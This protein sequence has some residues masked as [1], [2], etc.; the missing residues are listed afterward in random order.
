MKQ[1]KLFSILMMLVLCCGTVFAQGITITG[2]ITDAKTSES[3]PGASGVLK[4]TTQGTI[5]DMDGKYSISATPGA[6]LVI[7][8]IGY[9]TKEVKVGNQ[10]VI[11]VTLSEDSQS[12]DEVVIVGAS[13]KKSDLTGAISH[14]DAKVLEER[15]VTTVNE[16]LQGRVA[17]VLITK[18]TRPGDDSSI[19][20]RGVNTINSGSDPI[21]VVDGLV[22][23]N[24][25]GGFNAINVNDVASVQVLKD[26]SATAL[27]GSRGANGVVLITTK[28]GKIGEGRVTYDGWVGFSKI[29]QRP[30]TLNAQQ[31]FDLRVD[32]FANGYMHDNP[33]A[34][35]QDYID[36]TLMKT[37]TA[38]SDAEFETYRSGKS[39]NWLDEVISSGFQQ[40][41]SVSF[42]NATEKNNVYISFDYANIDGL[43]GD[44]KEK[45]YSGRVN[46]ESM[47]KPWLKIG[48]NSSFSR[49]ENNLPTDDVYDKALNA[50]PLLNPEP[51]RDPSTR[52]TWDY[53]TLYYRVHN[54]GN[55]NDYNPFNSQEVARER[56]RNRFLSSNYI[57]INPI[58]GLNIRSTFALDVSSQT[59]FEYT[60]SYIQ[61]AIRHYNGDAR[62]KHERWSQLN[63][64]WDNTITYDKTINKHRMNFL[65]G[66]STTKNTENYTKAQ[67]D[68]FASDDLLWN[69]LKGAAANDKKE[70]DSDFKGNTLVSVL[71]RVN[72]NYDLRYYLT[73]TARYDGSSKFA[74]GHRWG[75]LPSFSAAWD[76][77]NEAFMEDQT[78]FDRLKMRVGYGVVGNQDIENY[79]YRTLYFS[80]VSNGEASYA[81]SGLRGTPAITWEK[82]KQTNIGVDMAFL[83]D[84]L[85]V[86]LDGFFIKN[87]NL[88]M[89]HSLPLTSGYSETWEN[90]GSV[91]NKGFEATI[92]ATPIQTKDFTWNVNANISFDKNE[93]SKLY[94]DVK[95]ILN[96]S[97]REK[98]IFLGESLNNI[99]TY[100]TGG[101]A[102]ES[103]R[104]QWE[105]LDFNGKHVSLGDLFPLDVSGPD[106]VPDGVVD[107]LDRVVV[108]KKDPKF[109]G[110]FATDFNYKG[111]TLNAVFNY[112]YGAKKISSYYETLINSTGTS[113]A[114]EDLLNR[115]TPENT[116]A[117]VPRVIANTSSGYNRYN[118][119]DMDYTI[120]NAS[121]LRLSTLTLAYSFPKPLLSQIKVENLRVYFTASNLFCITKY[122]GFDP[123]TGDYGYP[124]TKMYVLGLN[125]SF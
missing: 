74:E 10:N 58:E 75:V 20:I 82:Q 71:G 25:Y 107:Q 121:Y 38:F 33:T 112:S 93:V 76:V 31:L 101:I 108:G 66:T 4:G 40:N 56:A 59:W 13:M 27:Y 7:S 85:N 122:K 21:Y 63:W 24:G 69:D 37:N 1:I 72:Y 26:A 123:E 43:I 119:S 98:N 34:N 14:V 54:E 18:G 49:T 104:S 11:N 97:E 60:P 105:N 70:L 44:S 8:Y 80:S 42:S 120:Q 102:N 103:N 95:E 41:H 47:I 114:S 16:A 22:M 46:A 28:K 113:M 19:K 9:D 118:P 89:K 6:T 36:N 57:N 77:T 124:P 92:N 17:G 55:N 12:I 90:I 88:L 115:W 73:A 67:G 48:T 78:I 94:G 100:K 79:A 39:Y 15:P 116:G 32:A 111:I 84:R 86:S 3:L 83:N 64:Q 52:Y 35:R 30:K 125:F 81:T 68:R 53:L 87:D 45:K 29:T 5:S 99:Y 96:G 65:F 50:N 61:E 110:G 109:Y 106:G 117:S 2:T 23:G 51:F 91:K 62:A